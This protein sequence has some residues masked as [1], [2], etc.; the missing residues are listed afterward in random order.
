MVSAPQCQPL[1]SAEHEGSVVLY[2]RIAPILGCFAVVAALSASAQAAPSRSSVSLV[3]LSSSSTTVAA[4]TVQPTFGSQVTYNI[5]TTA[6][7]PWV[8][9]NCFQNGTLVYSDTRG[10]FAG[11]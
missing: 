6:S 1:C 2:S 5:S 9:T 3:V 4:A 10:F 11:Y 8:E 7:Q